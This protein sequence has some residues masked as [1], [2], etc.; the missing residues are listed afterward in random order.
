MNLPLFIEEARG[1]SLQDGSTMTLQ[2]LA[3]MDLQKGKE[4]ISLQFLPYTLLA[5]LSDFPLGSLHLQLRTIIFNFG[6]QAGYRRM[7]EL[8]VKYGCAWILRMR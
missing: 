3:S 1:E 5:S 2:F 8:D 6:N 4:Q 7:M